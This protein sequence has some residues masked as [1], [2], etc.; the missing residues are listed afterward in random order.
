MMWKSAVGAA[1]MGVLIV[2]PA[3]AA[4]D[5]QQ[6]TLTLHER[7]QPVGPTGTDWLANAAGLTDALTGAESWTV[8]AP[9]D[10]SFAALPDGTVKHVPKPETKDKLQAL[11]ENRLSPGSTFAS[12]WANETITV[13]TES[14]NEIMIDGNASPFLFGNSQIL[15]IDGLLMP[16]SS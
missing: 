7:T 12:P 14:G 10:G 2:G 11:L 13:Q 3:Q 1:A 16:P 15:S 9:A 8:L 4:Q 5:A 6:E